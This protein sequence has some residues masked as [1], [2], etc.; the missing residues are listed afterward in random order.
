MLRLE[1]R[2]KRAKG[3]ALNRAG[4]GAAGAV[5]RQAAGILDDPAE[6]ERAV[7]R[8]TAALGAAIGDSI[9]NA[10]EASKMA[11]VDSFL[12]VHYLGKHSVHPSA[13]AAEGIS[14]HIVA[15]FYNTIGRVA[16]AGERCFPMGGYFNT[17]KESGVSA[18]LVRG[19]RE[20]M[21]TQYG[22]GRRSGGGES[23][24]L[25][26]SCASA[27][28]WYE[29][30]DG[31]ASD[32][33][34]LV[35]AAVVGALQ[36][37]CGKLYQPGGRLHHAVARCGTELPRASDFKVR[38]LPTTVLHTII[39]RAVSVS[40]R[41][42]LQSARDDDVLNCGNG[43]ISEND[44]ITGE[45]RMYSGGYILQLGKAFSVYLRAVTNGPDS[46]EAQVARRARFLAV[47]NAT[48]VRRFRAVAVTDDI[49]VA[50][51]ACLDLNYSW[52]ATLF[53]AMCDGETLALRRMEVFQQDRHDCEQ[54][55]EG[56]R[57]T[58]PKTKADQQSEGICRLKRHWKGCE[59]AH[60]ELK[61]FSKLSA[62]R[63]DAHGRLDGRTRCQVCAKRHLFDLQ[64]PAVA[65][66]ALPSFLKLAK[67]ARPS[68]EDPCRGTDEAATSSVVDF[69]R[70][71][72]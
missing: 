30:V 8:E 41:K 28:A 61:R 20:I 19:V 63:T 23:D 15:D 43:F 27:K 56:E 2:K 17:F 10:T 40:T 3:R 47:K 11:I 65:C 53:A 26:K 24:V 36:R 66:E 50:A 54:V 37:F 33:Y 16:D 45:V 4:A 32:C 12:L 52:D 57:V 39:Y 70:G 18:A 64:G 31:Q 14:G 60:D 67:R 13:K 5:E 22:G 7:E 48:R 68:W 1:S 25:L 9:S 35:R 49:F 21:R 58:L 72:L 71:D 29:S 55:K 69:V 34:A 42:W 38:W 62:C 44:A 46:T 59:F 51:V 6:R